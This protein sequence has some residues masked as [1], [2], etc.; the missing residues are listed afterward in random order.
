MI[1]S[2]AEKRRNIDDAVATLPDEMR[3]Q[4]VARLARLKPVIPK[5]DGMTVL[6][7]SKDFETAHFTVGLDEKTGAI[8]RLLA[9]SNGREWGIAGSSARAVHIPDLF[10]GRLREI[11][12]RLCDE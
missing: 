1:T 9:K 11:L 7:P 12:E 5:T 6:R 3:T 10:S 2:W 4:A 8:R